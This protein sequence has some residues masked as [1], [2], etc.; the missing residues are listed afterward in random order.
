MARMS[1]RLVAL[2]AVGGAV[3]SVVRW[4]ATALTPADGQVY[5][6]LVLNIVGSALVGWLA[7]AG[8]GPRSGQVVSDVWATG[9]IGFGGGVTTFATFA[10][11]IA[12]RLD[13]GAVASGLAFTGVTAVAAVGAAVAGFRVAGASR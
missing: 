8:H 3:G 4:A 9:A 12:I 7:G 6:I 13:E 1:P 5:T 2:V 10:V 11:Q